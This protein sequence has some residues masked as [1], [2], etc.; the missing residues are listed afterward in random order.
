MVFLPGFLSDIQKQ[1][2]T[3]IAKDFCNEDKVVWL[4]PLGRYGYSGSSLFLVFFGGKEH[5]IPYVV[6]INDK[7]KIEEEEQSIR[8]VRNFFIGAS[9]A[10]SL[11]LNGKGAVMYPHKG[12]KRL[13]DVEDSKTLD[14][15]L[16]SADFKLSKIS[17]ILKRNYEKN[18]SVAK[19]VFIEKEFNLF[20]E[21]C[22]YLR[23]EKESNDVISNLLGSALGVQSTLSFMGSRI[24]NPYKLFHSKAFRSLTIV[25]TCGPIHG[26]LH[27]SNIVLTAS[28][29]K[30]KLIDFAWAN[31]SASILK[32]F[33]LFESSIRFML[34]PK[35]INLKIQSK[36][37]KALMF[38]EFEKAHD[39]IND[40]S[41][42]HTFELLK[43]LIESVKCIREMAEK[44]SI[45]FSLNNYLVCQFIVLYGLLKYPSYN[46]Y[47]SVKYLGF[48]ATH[49]NKKILK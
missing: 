10:H 29:S 24:S 49:I 31:N 14:E 9:E 46:T 37:D 8:T 26:D 34:F 36:L 5:G 12:G 35:I 27:A 45:N 3:K 4:R 16:F 6:K 18:F 42:N 1:I 22:W 44:S 23:G 19:P 48:L 13:R 39:I 30:P 47:I 21:Y 7:D 28:N 33:V 41:D 38:S 15:V 17:K 32:D 25:D 20:D 40:I 2:I 43:R 11:F